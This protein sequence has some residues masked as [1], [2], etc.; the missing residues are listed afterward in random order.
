[1]FQ[2]LRVKLSTSVVSL[3]SHL[4]HQLPASS[5]IFQYRSFAG[6]NKMSVPG[7][8]PPK[9]RGQKPKTKSNRQPKGPSETT[10]LLAFSKLHVSLV[11]GLRDMT[12]EV[13]LTSD[14]HDRPNIEIIPS[15]ETKNGA[16]EK[17]EG[18]MVVVGIAHDDP[19]VVTLQSPASNGMYRYKYDEKE[20]LF[21]AEDRHE[22]VGMLCRD[23]LWSCK[24]M[25]KF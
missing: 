12:C 17:L 10:T 9:Q 21:L 18:E 8:T 22:L 25:P 23:L 1:M 16:T 20:E 15:Q 4:L 6:I 2:Q 13:N 3:P 24:G 19:V 11:H 5:P 7:R 14:F